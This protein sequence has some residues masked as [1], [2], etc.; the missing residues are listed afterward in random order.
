MEQSEISSIV[1]GIRSRLEALLA[2]TTMSLRPFVV[3]G[4][5][6][7]WLDDA[8]ASR[9]EAFDDVLSVAHDHIGFVDA[10]DSHGARSE[11]ME[12]VARQLS[13]EGLLSAWRDERYAVARAFGTSPAF[14]LERSA[15]RYFGIR[16][17]AAH[18]TGLVPTVKGPM[19]W[20]ARR[21]PSKAI[22]PGMLDN[23]VGGGIA[24]GMS[25]SDTL[26][27]E[28]WEEAG[29]PDAVAAAALPV[30]EIRICRSHPLGLERETVF[31]HDL[32]LAPAFTPMAIDGEVVEFLRVN[33][34]EAA[35]LIANR[36]GSDV[37]T[38]DASLVVVDWLLRNAA[39]RMT[40]ADQAALRGFC[41]ASLDF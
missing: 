32:E 38:A 7:G 26:L 4:D 17:Y 15:A 34:I 25:V 9:L 21:S 20:F 41:E 27:K 18:V 37:V 8:R 24:A 2:P 30:A 12:R 10:L 39:L 19:I 3:D 31:A 40:D 36:E 13:S 28:A 14:D 23:L 35:A 1:T 33:A 11:A 16:T 29:I 5:A 6:V 22:D